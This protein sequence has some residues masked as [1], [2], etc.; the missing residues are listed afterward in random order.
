MSQDFYGKKSSE[1]SEDMF[2]GLGHNLT[3]EEI[4]RPPERLKTIKSLPWPTTKRQL[5]GCLG[6]QE[7]T[8]PGSY[9]FPQ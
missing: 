1:L 7:K 5:K 3:A 8:A 9:M 2:H 4:S 6:L